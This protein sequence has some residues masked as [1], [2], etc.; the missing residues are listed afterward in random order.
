MVEQFDRRGERSTGEFVVAPRRA[1]C[2]SAAALT[3][4]SAELP[5]RPRRLGRFWWL[6]VVGGLGV[7]H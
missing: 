5:E 7:D 6:G 2:E 4:S 3:R 1:G